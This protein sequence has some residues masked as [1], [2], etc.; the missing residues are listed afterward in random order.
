METKNNETKA[1]GTDLGCCNPEDFKKMFE[2][3]SKCCPGQGDSPDF[4]ALKDDMMKKMM[5]ICYPPR[6]T[7]TKED[8]E[9]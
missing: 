7:D 9:I 1:K 4:S 2:K 3:M 6:A 8:N 5:E